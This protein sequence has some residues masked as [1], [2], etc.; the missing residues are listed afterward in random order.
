MTARAPI[1]LLATT[2]A[3]L[4][5]AAA[6]AKTH[7]TAPAP[8][9]GKPGSPCVASPYQGADPG[10]DS[11]LDTTSLGPAAPAPYEIGEPTGGSD[12]KR[13]MILIHGG[14]WYMV[15]AEA[16]RSM[17]PAAQPWR[18][19]GW[20]TVSVDYPACR[21]SL[22]GVLTFY[23]LVRQRVGD[24]VPIC[25]YGQSAGGTLA[26]LVAAM[27]P[28]VSCVIALGAPTNLR[29]IAAEG[30]AAA[31]G[32]TGPA[33][34]RAGTAY[35]QGLAR[36]AFGRRAL[37]RRSP[38]TWAGQIQA[39]LLLG[40]AA[41]DPLVPVV[42]SQALAGGTGGG[43]VDVDTLE[44]GGARWVHGTVS[45]AASDDFSHRMTEVVKPFGRGPT[46]PPPPA[47]PSGGLMLLGFRIPFL[48]RLV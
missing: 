10:P 38:V 22:L 1:A 20:E 5:P 31:A 9:T 39:R 21:E 33:T 48:G 2:A 42:Q 24:G 32:G 37:G 25:L 16:M 27:R 34:L 4:L 14:G 8:D 44:P 40:I 15:G 7:S 29:S 11:S 12:G 43:Y 47:P 13:V 45:D 36:A 35:A 19:A 46:S 3:L 17:R 23:D 26:L 30:A 18:A 28:A 41:N 6:G